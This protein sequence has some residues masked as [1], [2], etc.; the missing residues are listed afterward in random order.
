MWDM[1]IKGY[2]LSCKISQDQTNTLLYFHT[3][4]LRSHGLI[5]LKM[6][7]CACV[8]PSLKLE[9]HGDHY[10]HILSSRYKKFILELHFLIIC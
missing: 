8:M 5:K 6:I 3:M 4:I 7:P 9:V 2:I 10:E 1:N